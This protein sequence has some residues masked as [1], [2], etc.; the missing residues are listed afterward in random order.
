[1]EGEIQKMKK[2]KTFWQQAAVELTTA[3]DFVRWGASAFSRAQLYYGHGTD[4]AWDEALALVLHTL[5][6]PH[7]FADKIADARLTLSERR[8][9]LALF[10][11]RVEKRIPVPYL[12]HKAYFAGLEFY[13]DERVLIPRSPIAELIEQRFSP[14]L[15]GQEVT[16]ILEIGTGSGCIA[17]ACA[18]AFPDAQVDAVDISKEALAVAQKNCEAHA[19]GNQIRLVLGD[20]FPETPKT[21]YDLII[22]NPPYVGEVELKSLPPEY[23]QEPSL[24]LLAKCEGTDM[25]SRILKR[26]ARFLKP[27]GILVAEVGNTADEL[28]R[29]YPK[30]PFVWLEFERGGEGVF[31]LTREQLGG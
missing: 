26:A 6:L 27:K 25:V 29:R 2:N 3:R 11:K 15:D 4:N 5:A 23:H 20:L 12:T 13:V 1:M 28:V 10:K 16:H 19:V 17:I 7:E 8:E 31:L 9:V 14:W 18:K 21:G 24:A 22:S 30:L